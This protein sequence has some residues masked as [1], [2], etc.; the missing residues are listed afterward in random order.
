M[1]AQELSE[2]DHANRKAVSPEILEQVP[3]VAVILNND[4]AHFHL[5]RGV[6][7][8]KFCYR[9]NITPRELQE[10]P[11]HSSCV[12]VWCTVADFGVIGLCFF[13]EGGAM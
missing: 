12:T 3:A 5:S 6:N 10:Q 9:V 7:T 2:R 13:E 8:Q 1:L 4:E 11:L